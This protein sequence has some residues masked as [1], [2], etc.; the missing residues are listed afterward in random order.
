MPR[1]L[2]LTMLQSGDAVN[3]MALL[4]AL[5][6]DL[7]VVSILL[8]VKGMVQ[9]VSARFAGAPAGACLPLRLSLQHSSACTASPPSALAPAARAAATASQPLQAARS[10]VAAPADVFGISALAAISGKV[11]AASL[12]DP[13]AS[14]QVAALIQEVC[15]A[16]ML[17][18]LSP[19]SSRSRPR[20]C[21]D[22]PWS[23]KTGAAL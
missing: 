11:S 20:V 14:S 8:S 7:T 16:G 17:P 9:G 19:P 6:T 3:F 10:R 4:A 15:R 22:R 12:F 2:R 13:E 5:P 18:F 1:Q 21:Y 23:E